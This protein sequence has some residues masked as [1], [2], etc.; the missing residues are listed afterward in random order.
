[1]SDKRKPYLTLEDAR[2]LLAAVGRHGEM[3]L[4]L[5]RTFRE[6]CL[7]SP[8]ESDLLEREVRRAQGDADALIAHADLGGALD[9][10]E[11]VIIVAT[12]LRGGVSTSSSFQR[13]LNTIASTISEH[14]DALSRAIEQATD[15][16]QLETG[17]FALLKHC[18]SKPDQS[19]LK[20]VAIMALRKLAT[21]SGDI[22][23]RK[24]RA[25]TVL[26][27]VLSVDAATFEIVLDEA[28]K[29][30]PLR[31]YDIAKHPQLKSA[32][33]QCAGCHEI[34]I[35]RS[36]SEADLNAV[37]EILNQVDA[38]TFNPVV[39]HQI[40]KRYSE[41]IVPTL[42]AA[43]AVSR[44]L[45]AL[46]G[47]HE[48]N[49]ASGAAS[50]DAAALHRWS[51]RYPQLIELSSAAQRIDTA[52]SAHKPAVQ[53]EAKERARTENAIRYIHDQVLANEKLI[54]AVGGKKTPAALE[55]FDEF[56]KAPPHWGEWVTKEYHQTL[57]SF[58]VRE[59]IESPR[60]IG[61]IVI[62]KPASH[63]LTNQAKEAATRAGRPIVWIE[64]ATKKK[65]R[66]GVKTLVE[67]MQME[68][69]HS[70]VGRTA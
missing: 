28:L 54:V 68:A 33:E 52:R 67:R 1:M 66:E 44:V 34:V 47:M 41:A 40:L 11:A 63:A 2:A 13:S 45:E 23:V 58:Q 17:A 24:R 37:T 22:S 25:A 50:H 46:I 36:E 56:G 57:N 42:G 15:P 5:A 6:R 51:K 20:Q 53:S 4:L 35:K 31:S 27:S 7:I 14:I 61:V 29:I 3:Q 38:A 70:S 55:A 9:S 30:G 60:C 19:V 10:T 62:T 39:V 49:S 12:A 21:F 32:C 8:E 48:K 59:Q 43:Q 64:E 65:I 26:T 16:D 69:D 18:D